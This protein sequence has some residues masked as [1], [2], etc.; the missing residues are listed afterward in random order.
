MQKIILSKD[1]EKKQFQKEYF[2]VTLFTV[3]SALPIRRLMDK[4]P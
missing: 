2:G 1:G 4:E 3:T